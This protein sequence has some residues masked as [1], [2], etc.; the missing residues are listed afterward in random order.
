MSSAAF[1]Q[2]LA[3]EHAAW[4]D[5]IDLLSEEEGALMR[6]DTVKLATLCEPK[7]LRLQEITH[8]IQARKA[9]LVAQNFQADHDGMAAW[10][11]RNGK[12]EAASLWNRLRECET[13]ARK[14]HERI[15]ILLDMRM[16]ATRQALNVLFTAVTGQGGGYNHEG[17]VVI[18]SGG[19]AL[20]S[21]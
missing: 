21:V 3:R 11:A 19:R 14:L 20:I 12:D 17:M 13:R 6:G 18:P 16:A 9:F 1:I 7:L 2:E 15:A 4:L 10:L 8:F 5:L